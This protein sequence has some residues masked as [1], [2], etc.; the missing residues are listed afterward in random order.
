MIAYC[1]VQY[2]YLLF[3]CEFNNHTAVSLSTLPHAGLQ[4]KEKSV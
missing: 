4:E 1:L 2:M 3:E